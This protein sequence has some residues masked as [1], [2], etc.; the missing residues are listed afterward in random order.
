MKLVRFH[1]FSNNHLRMAGVAVLAVFVAFT[2]A[3]CGSTK[4]YTAD[5]TVVYRESIYNVSNVQVLTRKSEGVISDDQVIDLSG[6]EK[7][8]FNDLLDQHGGEIFVRQAFML[9]DQELVYQAQKVGSWSDFSRMNKK[10]EG[11]AK[12]MQKFLADAKKT[13]LKLK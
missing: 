5:K 2:L 10:F 12:D 1:A 9:D 8:G 3:S 4:V 11:A 6:T 13:Q 7:R